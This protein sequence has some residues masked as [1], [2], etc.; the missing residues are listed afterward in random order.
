MTTLTKDLVTVSRFDPAVQSYVDAYHHTIFWL[1]TGFRSITIDFTE[2]S[3][4]D[5]SIYFIA[6]G[7]AVRVTYDGTPEGWMISFSP[8]R[9]TEVAGEDLMIRNVDVLSAFGDIPKIILSPKIGDRITM[10]AEMID[11]LSGSQIPNKEAAIVS[12]LK[13]LLIYC[14]SRCNVRI[15][16]E[17]R[18]GHVHIVTLFKALV[19]QHFTRLHRVSDYAAMMNISAK[20]LNAAVKDVLGV[21]A[22]SVIQEQLTIQARRELKF[23]N[24]S[25]K[26]IAFKLGFSE[27]F[28]FSNYFKKQ[29][30][31]SPSEYRTL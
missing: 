2:L 22:K 21:T 31:C 7:R 10:L 12:L 29:I 8:A 18:R 17:G 20:Y 16:D 30:G 19:A 5:S 13:T 11:E 24:D 1:K 4:E 9:F 23:S 26:E 28:Y 27:P 6:P 15:H 14:D 25:I 3:T